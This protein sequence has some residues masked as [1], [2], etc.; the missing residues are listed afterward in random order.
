MR[1]LES[2]SSSH[3][4]GRPVASATAA[5]IV[6]SAAGAEK[7]SSGAA[8]SKR[9]TR[10]LNPNK[11]K[12][13]TVPI[14]PAAR[15]FA[16]APKIFGSRASGVTSASS[17]SVTQAAIDICPGSSPLRAASQA[18][19]MPKERPRSVSA[20]VSAAIAPAA[21]AARAA[22]LGRSAWEAK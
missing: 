4:L 10:R 6:A 18:K 8:M 3:A 19:F 5:S 7:P 15:P 20:S 13:A 12:K 1:L 21:I 22:L 17:R 2:V 16:E 9:R 14:T 11:A